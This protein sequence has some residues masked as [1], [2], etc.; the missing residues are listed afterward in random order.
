M[1]EPNKKDPMQFG[2]LEKTEDPRDLSLGAITT[3]PPL[4]ELPE[5]FELEILGI[6]DQKQT[7]FC[8]TFAGTLLSEIQEG[9]PLSPE[10][11][12]AKAKELL[13]DYTGWGLQLRDV[14]KAK[15]KKGCIEQRDAPYSVENKDRE[16]LANWENWPKELDDKAL[17]HRKQS[18]F[19][20]TGQYDPFDNARAAIWHFRE[21]KQGIEFGVQFGWSSSRVIF[22]TIPQGG[23][24]HA[25]AITGFT[26]FEDGMPVLIIKNS[27][28]E[29][30]GV[31]GTHYITREVYNHFVEK[32][33]HYMMVD[34]EL[35]QA[36]YMTDRG[37]KIG[38]NWLI[39]LFKA[40]FRLFT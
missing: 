40:F 20:V 19:D 5:H 33:G 29:S 17:T 21:K 6:K 23:F 2:L 26:T 27:Y 37:I 22:D 1:N 38:D 8:G 10:Y 11:L 12:F 32:Y 13:G 36:R 4:D 31:K 35:E 14:F 30:A 39:Q 28:G 16:F 3:L 9:V 34:I 15:Q 7:D 25:L 24:G 18:Y